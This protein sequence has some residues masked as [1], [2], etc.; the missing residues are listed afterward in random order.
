MVIP[1]PK[2]SSSSLEKLH[3]YEVLVANGLNIEDLKDVRRRIISIN[4]YTDTVWF[5]KNFLINCINQII[6]ESENE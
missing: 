5:K 4:T 2:R 6:E 1:T 3:H